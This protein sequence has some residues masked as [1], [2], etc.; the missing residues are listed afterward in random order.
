MAETERSP[1]RS[2]ASS[3][4]PPA[5]AVPALLA[6]ADGTCFHGCNFGASGEAFGEVCFNTGMVGY[7]EVLTDPS[8]HGQ[9]VTMT[10]PEV[11]NY[12]INPEDMESWR[13]W[14]AGFVV[15]EFNETPSNWRATEG[16]GEYLERNGIVGITGID[17]RMLT[18]H[19]RTYGAQMGA[20]SSEDL[21]EESLV[22]KVRQ[23]PAYVGRDLAQDV[24]CEQ[25]RLWGAAGYV[26]DVVADPSSLEL[27]TPGP[28]PAGPPGY[29]DEAAQA[30]YGFRVVVLD[31][32]VKQNILRHL[33]RRGCEVIVVPASTSAEDIMA[34]KPHG[35]LLSPGPGDP[36][37]LTYV[38]ETVR[39]LIPQVPIFGVCM[40]QHMLGLA[41]GGKTYK[42]KFGHRGINHPVR[43]IETGTVEI[44]TQN[45]GFCVDP[46]TLPDSIEITHINLNDQSLEGMRDR[47]HPVFSVQYHPEA[48]PGPHDS[49]YLFDI[50]I[51]N[52]RQAHQ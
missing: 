4:Q 7:Q 49:H 12:G 14:V 33:V 25:P 45:H 22:A 43:R 26:E 51:E 2:R 18:K 17:T 13:P 31:L 9:I 34:F 48:G 28:M 39:N 16:L 37:P 10:Y 1:R 19:L 29:R 40:G 52:M 8:Y 6:L 50:F 35:V 11:G 3:F 15:R 46:D 38:I 36:E 27:P 23:A 44:T 41:Y 42:L 24:T 5:S 21:S 20:V 47:D 32:G 30:W